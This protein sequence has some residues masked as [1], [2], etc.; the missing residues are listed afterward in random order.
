MT[1]FEGTR[2]QAEKSFKE[3][4]GISV[5]EYRRYSRKAALRI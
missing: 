4:F 2:K 5:K 1:G 3:W